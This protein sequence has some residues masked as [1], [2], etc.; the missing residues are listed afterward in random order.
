[1]LIKGIKVLVRMHQRKNIAMI[2]ISKI[3]RSAPPP[4]VMKPAYCAQ[5]HLVQNLQLFGGEIF[6]IRPLFFNLRLE[7][8]ELLQ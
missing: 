6:I 7:V 5:F 3:W 8:Q 1:M 4:R 2:L